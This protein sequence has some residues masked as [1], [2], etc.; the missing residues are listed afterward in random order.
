MVVSIV[1]NNFKNDS[2]VLKENSTLQKAGYR[3]QVVALH[4]E[5]LKEREDVQS[6]PVHRVKLR[7][8][9]WSKNKFIQLLKYFEFI[10][11]VV[12]EYKNSN[13]IHC[14]DLNTL[15]IGVIVKKF[16]NKNTKII[17]DAHEYEINDTPNE[18]RYKI[19]I[20]YFLERFLIKYAD[21]VITVSDSIANAYVALYNI[22]KPTLVLNTPFYKNI[23]KK[24]IFRETLGI[25]KEQIIFL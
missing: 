24:D 25:K 17:Y 8:R 9:N 13:I 14:N 3:V 12:K 10:Y 7:S 19:K 22:E 4:E 15:P 1:L 18:N 16:F 5:P 21:K 11:R 2:R 6:I 20:K 23:E